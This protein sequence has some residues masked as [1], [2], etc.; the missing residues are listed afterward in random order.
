M[1][2][3]RGGASESRVHRLLCRF[4]LLGGPLDLLIWYVQGEEE[5]EFTTLGCDLDI[6]KYVF[7]MLE[8]IR[9][10]LLA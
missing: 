5:E 7:T 9:Q 2:G 10:C 6:C 4:L 8:L 1:L 3:A